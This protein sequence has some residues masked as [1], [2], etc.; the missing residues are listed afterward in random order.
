VVCGCH[1]SRVLPCLTMRPSL[2]P[3]LALTSLALGLVLLPACTW[4][5][6]KDVKDRLSV[7]DDDGDGYAAETDCNDGDEAIHPDAEEAWYDGVDQDCAGD[8]DYDADKDRFVSDAYVGLTTGG[9]E[10]SGELPGGD[11]NDTDATILPGADDVYYDGVDQDCAG[12][13]D[14]DR[15]LDGFVRDEDVGATTTGVPGSGELLGGDCD[16]DALGVHPGGVDNWYDGIDSDCA[17]NDDYDQDA[18][19]FHTDD[20]TIV[21]GATLYVEGSGV[22]PGG[23]CNDT[24]PAYFPGATDAWY[25]GYDKNCD[26]VSDWDQDGDGYDFPHGGSGDDCDD[27]DAGVNPAGVEHLG[28]DVDNDCDDEPDRFALFGIEGLTWTAAHDPQFAAN[29]SAVYLSVPDAQVTVDTQAY[30]DSAAAVRWELADPLAVAG[31]DM[32]NNNTSD[33]STFSVGEGQGFAVDDDYIYGLLSLDLSTGHG[34]RFV[35]YDLA[36]GTR[37]GANVQ[38]SGDV[39]SYADLSFAVDNGSMLAAAGD[40]DGNLTFSRVDDIT[41]ATYD[42]NHEESV[43]VDRVAFTLSGDVPVYGS[44]GGDL[45]GYDFDAFGAE[46]GFSA[47]TVATGVVPADLDVM[48]DVGFPILVEAL[49]DDGLVRLYD[50]ESASVT[51]VRAS[52]VVDVAVA[53]S[54]SSGTWYVAWSDSAGDVHLSFGASLLA[55]DTLDWDMPG[56]EAEVAAWSAGGVVWMAVTADGTVTVGQVEE[57]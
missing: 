15:D 36:A 4:V 56:T 52:Q 20:D 22:L 50:V 46:E 7:V 33:P 9:V 35:R 45:V 21:Y 47:S 5:S 14:Y 34:L 31:V 48:D 43:G 51:D 17:G 30:Y 26:G 42:V 25:D 28:D 8:D 44:A 32:W 54:E 41:T 49:T 18:D 55:L 11:C 1:A 38:S 16:D 6:D 27:L 40:L 13:D 24:E 23:D 39:A 29:S 37:D 3:S 12:D 10:G 2:P 53:R 19:G 57:G